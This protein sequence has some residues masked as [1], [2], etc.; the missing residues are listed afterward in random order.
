M[1]RDKNLLALLTRMKELSLRFTVGDYTRTEELFEL[2]KKGRYPALVADMA[3]AFGMMIVKIE[4]REF[5]LENTIEDLEKTKKE[6][7]IAKARLAEENIALK[8]EVLSLAIEIDE[9]KKA[10]QV[11]EITETEYFK[12]I[13][14][15]AGEIRQG[16]K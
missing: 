3:E 4:A 9:H 7:E 2:A 13:Q 5:S 6:L 10:E 14:K 11:A 12:D 15:K 8:K 1:D 16:S